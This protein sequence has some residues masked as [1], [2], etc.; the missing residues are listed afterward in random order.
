[1][2]RR[3]KPAYLK[4]IEGMQACYYNE[5][6]DCSRCPY[7]KYNEREFYQISTAYCMEKLNEDAR[8]WAESMEFFT[9]C[10][11]CVCFHKDRDENNQF[12]SSSEDIHDGYCSI[13]NTMMNET[14]Y[15]SRGGMKG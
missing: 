8:K 11:D 12:R 9:N 2:A 7:D 15:C 4:I 1:M 10:G 13:W 14:E 6:R 5:E 3:K